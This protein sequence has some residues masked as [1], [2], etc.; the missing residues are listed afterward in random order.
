MCHVSA[1]NAW[2]VAQ[3]SFDVCQGLAES[4]WE[5]AENSYNVHHESS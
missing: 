1:Q 3:S 5:V 2:E 4:S